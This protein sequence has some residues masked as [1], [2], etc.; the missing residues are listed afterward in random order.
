LIA[1]RE[2]TIAGA[3]GFTLDEFEGNV[4]VFELISVDEH[5]IRFLLAE[6]ERRVLEIGHFVSIEIDVNA[7]APSMQRTLL[8]LGYLPVAYV[9]A[10]AFHQVERLDVLKMLRLLRRFEPGRIDI[11]EA[12]EAIARHVVGGFERREALPRLGKLVGRI[13]LFDGLTEEQVLRLAGACG[14][15]TYKQ[16]DRL[17]MIGE[18]SSELLFVMEG[19]VRIEL[20]DAERVVGVVGAGDSLGEVALLT[21]TAHSASATAMTPVKVGVLP[22][23][24]LLELMRQRPDI[25]VVLY[26]NLA[27]GLGEKLRRADRGGSR[28][29]ARPGR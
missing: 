11:V 12:A 3:V 5:A 21:G 18:E 8:E 1:H 25:A 28:G 29:P 27:R 23:R 22:R 14:Q 9:P 17:F 16:G 7:D 19:R 10:L 13:E 6:L 15:R 4:R 2:D 26:R 24:R 20:D